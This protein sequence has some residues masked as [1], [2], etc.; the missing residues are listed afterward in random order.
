M[1][2]LFL[3]LSVPY[4]ALAALCAGLSRRPTPRWTS[5]SA[6]RCSRTGSRYPLLAQRIDLAR[7]YLANVLLSPECK[8][9][10]T[11][12]TCSRQSI[13][14]CCDHQVQPPKHAVLLYAMFRAQN[15]VAGSGEGAGLHAD[16]GSP[17]YEGA[18]MAPLTLPLDLSAAPSLSLPEAA[19]PQHTAG[20]GPQQHQQL[21]QMAD[22]QQAQQHQQEQQKQQQAAVPGQSHISDDDRLRGGN[23]RPASVQASSGEAS[24]RSSADD[25][26]A[27]RQSAE[28][29]RTP[30]QAPGTPDEQLLQQQAQQQ[31]H[32]VC[33]FCIYA[34]CSSSCFF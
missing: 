24:K 25:G 22:Q 28:R 5:S 31:Q 18:S 14:A 4:R 34:Y 20:V 13:A 8:A 21:Q 9:A 33:Q 1:F 17:D 12:C 2:I 16:A 15:G 3:T 11:H 30:S 10:N 27:S 29:P 6:G 23:S 32:Q 7:R 19:A 26:A